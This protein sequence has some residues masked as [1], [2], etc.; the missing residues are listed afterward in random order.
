[1]LLEELNSFS[2]LISKAI[3]SNDW[4]GLSEILIRRQTRLEELLNAPLS[5][6][7]QRT[8]GSVM[9]SVQAMDKLFINAVQF[10]KTE[11]L[12]QFQAVSQ[13]QKVMRAYAAI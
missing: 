9:E 5:E 3:E 13:G 1:M 11:L 12:K 10:K 6:E 8:I 2:L 4:E 7:D